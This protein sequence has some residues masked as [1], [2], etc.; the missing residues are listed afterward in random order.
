MREGL[1]GVPQ[2]VGL[3]AGRCDHPGVVL[4][5]YWLE[6]ES[7]EPPDPDKSVTL[8]CMLPWACGVT[9][10]DEEDALHQLADLFPDGYRRHRA[11]RRLED[12]DLSDLA[13]ELQRRGRSFDFGIPLSRGVWYPHVANP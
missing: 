10:F 4:R 2:I 5:R 8:D 7:A 9:A 11:R 1:S 6:F 12:V 3:V 13:A